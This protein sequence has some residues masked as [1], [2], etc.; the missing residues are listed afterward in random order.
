M[1]LLRRVVILR[2][3]FDDSASLHRRNRCNQQRR[4]DY[5]DGVGD[6]SVAWNPVVET[7]VGIMI[8]GFPFHSVG[9]VMVAMLMVDPMGV[10]HAFSLVRVLKRRHGE[11]P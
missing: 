5:V 4:L 7:G 9:C 3:S 11:S 10:L 8:V 1:Q 2:S 6:F